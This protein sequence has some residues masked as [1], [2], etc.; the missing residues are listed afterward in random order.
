MLQYNGHIFDAS[1]RCTCCV[2]DAKVLIDPTGT[3]PLSNKWNADFRRRVN[4]LRVATQQMISKQDILGLKA[5]AALQIM[6]PGI[7]NLATRQEMFQRWVNQALVTIVADNDMMWMWP[8]VERAY[9]MGTAYAQD[10]LDHEGAVVIHNASHRMDALF[11]LT[12]MELK[13][14]MDATSQQA[15][16][17]ANLGIATRTKPGTIVRGIWEVYERTLFNRVVALVGMMTVKTFGDATLDLYQTA[18]VKQVGLIPEAAYVQKAQ[19]TAKD[20]TQVTDAVRKGAGSRVSRLQTPSKSTIGRI[21]KQELTLAKKLGEKVN[22]RTAGDDDV[23]IICEGISEDGPYKLD[24]ARGLIPA[25]P[26]CRCTFV[27]VKDKRFAQSD[28]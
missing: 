23:C 1:P 27:P 9:H 4:Q 25:H 8:Y 15:T 17:V 7:T 21:R 12:K 14:I 3:K 10:Q 18:G 2:A 6:S 11:A 5:G 20:G 24:T 26:H 13:G 19:Q 16:R 22:V 28:D